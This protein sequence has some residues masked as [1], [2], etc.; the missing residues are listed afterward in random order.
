[1]QPFESQSINVSP[2]EK[3]L[4]QGHLDRNRLRRR[5][6]SLEKLGE[7]CSA[8]FVATP[9]LGARLARLPACERSCR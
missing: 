6:R 1:M 3:A 2:T 9:L 4:H 5:F 8:P 7:R